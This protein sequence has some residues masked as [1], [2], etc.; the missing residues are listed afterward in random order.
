[1]VPGESCPTGGS[2]ISGL[3]F[4]PN[5]PYPAE[6]DGALFFAD[7]VRGCIWAME[8]APGSGTP[9]P[10]HIKTFVAPA[11][12]PVDLKRG[13]DGNLYYVDFYGGTVKKITYTPGASSARGAPRGR[14]PASAQPPR[15]PG[16]RRTGA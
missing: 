13:P 15:S 14:A 10:S 11:A 1:M 8:R 6:Y 5:G 7:A 12:T 2:A 4:Y 3:A 16:R 9:S